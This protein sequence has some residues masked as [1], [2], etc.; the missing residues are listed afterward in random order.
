[1]TNAF[2]W[3]SPRRGFARHSLRAA[4]KRGSHAA[5]VSDDAVWGGAV[6][7]GGL[8]L[9]GIASPTLAVKLVFF[10]GAEGDAAT[11]GWNFALPAVEFVGGADDPPVYPGLSA[12]HAE[13]TLRLVSSE[14][15]LT[16]DGGSM[17]LRKQGDTSPDLTFFVARNVENA[18]VPV[19]LAGAT[20]ALRWRRPSGLLV[21]RTPAVVD[22]PR[23]ECRLELVADDTTE[24]GQH[25]LELRVTFADG[26]V[27]T[28]P[29]DGYAI[30]VVTG[31]EF[32]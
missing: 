7:E 13:R 17:V 28:F 25:L 16:V 31:S 4:Y 26:K 6:A 8:A 32:D 29:G 18:P 19:D 24:E 27:E 2:G 22:A 20:L 30:V 15:T 12:R 1:M 5:F 9:G 3:E 10:G 23:G 14:S 21:T 11:A